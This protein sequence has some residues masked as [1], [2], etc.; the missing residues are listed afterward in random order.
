MAAGLEAEPGGSL[1]PRA[2]L[3]PFDRPG[4]EPGCLQVRAVP[5]ET[6][7]R[8][9]N[10]QPKFLLWDNSET[11]SFQIRNTAASY[12]WRFE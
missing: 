5:T 3:L 8:P 1:L 10:L 7:G 9:A 12:L 11:D 2:Y 4:A 6:L